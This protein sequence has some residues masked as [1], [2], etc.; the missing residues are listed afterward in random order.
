MYL[1]NL[2]NAIPIR[3]NIAAI[4]QYHHI[5]LGNFVVTVFPIGSRRYYIRMISNKKTFFFFSLLSLLTPVGVIYEGMLRK[6]E[7]P[8]LT[9]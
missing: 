5:E 7:L 2:K 3:L 4:A 6:H 9:R 8:L 1:T